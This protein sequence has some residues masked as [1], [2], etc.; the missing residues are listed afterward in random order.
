MKDGVSEKGLEKAVDVVKDAVAAHSLAHF[1]GGLPGIAPAVVV[2]AGSKMI[3][4]RKAPYPFLN[5]VE[6]VVDKSI[7]SLYAPQWRKLAS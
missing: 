6:K 1:L 7:G 3:R 2:K 4:G 5:R